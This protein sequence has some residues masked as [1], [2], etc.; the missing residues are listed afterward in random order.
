MAYATIDDF[1]ARANR[2]LSTDER[3]MASVLLEDA[4]NAIDCEF[5]RHHM[6]VPVGA[7]PEYALKR[8]SVELVQRVMSTSKQHDEWGGQSVDS[9]VR[10]SWYDGNGELRISAENRRALGLPIKVTRAGFASWA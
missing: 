1:I 5:A 8:V 4:A 7:V 9:F 2:G 6:D 3:E 10:D